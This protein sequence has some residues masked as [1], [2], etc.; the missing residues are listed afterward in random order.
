MIPFVVP[1]CYGDFLFG[2]VS[3]FI[4]WP[5]SFRIMHGKWP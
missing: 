2:L 1:Q 5:I 4:I 3:G